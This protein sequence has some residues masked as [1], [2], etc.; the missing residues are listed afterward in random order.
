MHIGITFTLNSIK[1]SL[2]YNLSKKKP[3]KKRKH[4]I[5]LFKIT[6][7]ILLIK[8]IKKHF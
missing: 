8:N 7:Q 4:Y 3:Y 1:L 5:N 2:E 6:P